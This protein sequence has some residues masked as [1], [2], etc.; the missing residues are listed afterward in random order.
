MR[1]TVICR[2]GAEHQKTFGDMVG[3][4]LRRHGVAVTVTDSF[5]HPAGD[6]IVAWGWKNASR[7]IGRWPVLVMERGY[8][9]D[10]FHWTSLGWNGLNG[11][12]DF[13]NAC[14]DGRRWDRF[15]APFMQPWRQPKDN[16]AL[17]MGQVPGDQSLVGHDFNN[18]IRT[19]TGALRVFGFYP[20]FRPHPKALQAWELPSG[21]DVVGGDLQAALAS[22]AVVATFNSN[23]GVD[24]ALAGVPTVVWDEGSMAWAVGAQRSIEITMPDRTRWAHRLA[25]CQWAPQELEAGDWWPQLREAMPCSNTTTTARTA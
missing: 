23:S 17:I 3:T 18:W 12:A 16:T 8:V 25:H 22:A 2:R 14:V 21:L 11:R 10:R 13:G 9:G 19:V 5:D 6:F 20:V 24:A 4:G 7:Y 15:F 1:C